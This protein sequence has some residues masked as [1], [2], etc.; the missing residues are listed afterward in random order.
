MDERENNN[1]ENIPTSR[2]AEILWEEWK[3]R[4]GVFWDSI[5]RWGLVVGLITIAPYIRP[6]MIEDLGVYVLIFPILAFLLGVFSSWHLAAEYSRLSLVDKRFR[7]FLR[8]FRPGKIKPRTLK[9][10]LFG[11][12]I[13][14][15]IPLTFLFLTIFIE[16]SSI[17]IL[18]LLQK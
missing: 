12:S 9:N 14:K 10:F 17:L 13:G 2:I 4:H 7:P 5:Y 8:E 16:G 1:K 18:I 15:I 6:S 3:Y 11:R